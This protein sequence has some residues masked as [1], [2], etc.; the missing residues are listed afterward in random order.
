MPYFEHDGVNFYYEDDNQ[1]KMPFI[2]LHGLGGDTNQT[3]DVLK[4]IKNVR[5]ITMDFRGHGK[6]IKYGDIDSFNFDTFADDVRAL[7]EHLNLKTFYLGGISTGAGVALNF[8]VRYPNGLEKLI[9]SRPAWINEEQPKFIRDA[10]KEIYTILN[11]SN[12]IQKKEKFKSTDI[13]KMMN[14]KSHYAGSTLLGQFDY[15]YAVETSDKLVR[16]P[17]DCPVRDKKKWSS[18]PIPTLILGSK[19]DPIHPFEFGEI[20]NNGIPTSEFKEITSKTDSGELHKKDSVESINSFLN[21]E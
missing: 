19:K 15:P 21:G 12:I 9:L 14:E 8:S 7:V 6:T 11:A 1:K 13:Y 18:I 20:L 10:F 16:M 4:E 5:C 2:F 3:T 17:N